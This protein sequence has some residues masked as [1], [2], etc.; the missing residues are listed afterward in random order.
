MPFA[1]TA[2]LCGN[3]AAAGKALASW[4]QNGHPSWTTRC[5]CGSLFQPPPVVF[6]GLYGCSCRKCT[7]SFFESQSLSEA[8]EW[9]S[10]Y[11][12]EK[13]LEGRVV[14]WFDLYAGKEK[15]G[16]EGGVHGSDSRSLTPAICSAL[17]SWAGP[18]GGKGGAHLGSTI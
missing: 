2:F 18:G 3:K 4:A 11:S 7:L 5:F 6:T 16:Q 13:L 12:K 17:E 8:K 10:A 9:N 14:L 15:A 1:S